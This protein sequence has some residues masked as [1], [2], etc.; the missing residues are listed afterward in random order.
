MGDN[1]NI[2]RSSFEETINFIVDDLDAAIN[3]EVL[4]TQTDKT[5]ATNRCGACIE[6]TCFAVCCQRYAP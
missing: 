3:S 5:R 6:I 2:P 1:Y 4:A